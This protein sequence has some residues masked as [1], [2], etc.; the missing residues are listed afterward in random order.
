VL[1]PPQS[2]LQLEISVSCLPQS[3]LESA[4]KFRYLI[5]PKVCYSQHRNFGIMSVAQVYY[6]QRGNFSIVSATKCTTVSAEILLSCPPLSVLQSATVSCLPSKEKF[7]YSVC[8][9]VCYCHRRNFGI[10]PPQSVLQ[11]AR[12]FRYCVCKCTIVSAEISVLVRYKMC[13]SQ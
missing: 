9:K 6:I 11:S 10:G 5:R 4:W 3:V 7:W 1:R 12:K 8:R 2:V 13:Y